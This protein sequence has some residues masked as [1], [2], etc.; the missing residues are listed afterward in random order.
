VP[1]STAA[2]KRTLGR[3]RA[4]SFAPLQRG[5]ACRL[6]GAVAAVVAVECQRL[7]RAPRG[8]VG[9]PGVR[10]GST[11]R[12]GAPCD[13]EPG[14]TSAPQLPRRSHARILVVRAGLPAPPQI[15][16]LHVESLML[17]YL[18]RRLKPKRWVVNMKFVINW[19]SPYCQDR[20]DALSLT[21]SATAVTGM[22][23]MSR[24]PRER[25]AVLR[26][27]EQPAVGAEG[28]TGSSSRTV[29]PKARSRAISSQGMTGRSA[30]RGRPV[31]RFWRV[32]S[33]SSLSS[34]KSRDL[35]S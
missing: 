28:T 7:A 9:A 14:R 34:I 30:L 35:V 4:R 11:Q 22:L 10:N 3:N 20:S 15:R 5:W 23:P 29:S 25:A 33:K 19:I 18:A 12:G 1:V 24:S 26:L 6:R 32:M 27:Y 17:G 31:L 21:R 16:M 8:V 13:D 2:V